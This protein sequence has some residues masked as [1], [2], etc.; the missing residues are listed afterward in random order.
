MVKAVF[1]RMGPKRLHPPGQ[2]RGQ[3]VWRNRSLRLISR[4][5]I[6][7]MSGAIAPMRSSSSGQDG[8]LPS[9]RHGFESR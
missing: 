5:T 4:K 7:A 8:C 1:Y 6:S 9:S 3:D 2:V